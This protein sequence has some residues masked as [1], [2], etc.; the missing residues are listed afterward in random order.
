[1]KACQHGSHR[2][3]MV[4]TRDIP[5]F[6]KNGRERT[7]CF[8]LD[9]LQKYGVVERFRLHSFLERRSLWR[10]LALIGKW[11][12]GL[13][14]GEPIPFQVLLF[15]S[16]HYLRLLEKTIER[17]RPDAV[18]FDG[19]RAGP[20]AVALRHRGI[21][22]NFICDFDDLMSRRMLLLAEG[23]QPISMGYL[24]ELVPR[25]VQ[26]HVLG[27]RG[28]RVIQAY[29]Y[30]ALRRI[31]NRIALACNGVVLV[32]RIDAEHMLQQGHRITVEIIPPFMEARQPMHELKEIRRF[33]FVGSDNQRQNFL[34]IKHLMEMWSRMHPVTELHIYGKQSFDYAS[35][36]GVVF[37]GFVSDIADAYAPGSVMLAPSFLDGG[38]KTKV[39]E[40]FSYGVPVVGTEIT[41]AGISADC[42]ALTV[43]QEQLENLVLN[44][45]KWVELIDSA[46]ASVMSEIKNNHS[47]D[48]LRM[49]WLQLV[50]PDALDGEASEEVFRLS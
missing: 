37:H 38:V 21:N 42:R 12:L 44:P 41:F 6:P 28:A 50:F 7:M 48:K 33:V 23:R 49:R 32:S 10:I 47:S 30:R 25:W 18:Y 15:Y 35:T 22:L 11:F 20:Y 2:V 31:E 19:V 46:S 1:M 3:L 40:A 45:E 13:V 43:T 36:H 34:T 17:Y 9:T 26:R 24:K 27:G 4:L 29:E 39:L 8:I 5:E 16:P 14:R